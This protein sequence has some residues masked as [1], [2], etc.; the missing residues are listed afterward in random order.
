M[1]HYRAYT[2][3]I[4]SDDESEVQKP[5]KYNKGLNLGAFQATRKKTRSTAANHQTE[6][7]YKYHKLQ[8]YDNNYRDVVL[9]E[10]YQIKTGGKKFVVKHPSFR[11][12]IND[13][14]ELVKPV[15]YSNGLYLGASQA[16]EKKPRS[17]A[18]NYQ[19]E[20][21]H[22]YHKLQQ[23]DNYNRDGVLPEAYEIR[24]GGKKF[25]VKHPSIIRRINERQQVRNNIK[26]VRL[27]KRRSPCRRIFSKIFVH[28]K[29]KRILDMVR[30]YRIKVICEKIYSFVSRLF[31][32]RGYN[33]IRKRKTRQGYHMKRVK[34][35]PIARAKRKW[36]IREEITN[37]LWT[38]WKKQRIM[39]WKRMVILRFLCM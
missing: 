37:I 30:S 34:V 27:R 21:M 28:F 24:A 9:P 5:A 8:Q 13:E 31:E 22:K 19:S 6:G 25:V 14:S 36:R 20:G 15:L 16:A 18:T 39:Y 35:K 12:R 4:F 23:Y 29:M 32:H 33:Q 7:M 38:N 1:S 11:R 17:T 10:V 3:V 26:P 2:N